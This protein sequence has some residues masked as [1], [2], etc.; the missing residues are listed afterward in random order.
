MGI[1]P[2][3]PFHQPK[4]TV[5][6][7]GIEQKYLSDCDLVFVIDAWIKPNWY[8]VL[9]MNEANHLLSIYRD[10]FHTTGSISLITHHWHCA[11]LNGLLLDWNQLF[12]VNK[13][14]NVTRPMATTKRHHRLLFH[15]EDWSPNSHYSTPIPPWVASNGSLAPTLAFQKDMDKQNLTSL[16]LDSHHLRWWIIRPWTVSL[17]NSTISLWALIERSC[18]A[19]TAMT[20]YCKSNTCDPW[21]LWHGFV[22]K[23]RNLFCDGLPQ[24]FQ[25]K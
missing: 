10:H 20:G 16:T 12:N 17:R 25:F 9:A 13:K 4:S 3:K 19:M 22:S 24:V 5:S 7:V 1:Q 2:R 11:G 8:Q 14:T 21:T 23:K 15:C 18:E 6:L